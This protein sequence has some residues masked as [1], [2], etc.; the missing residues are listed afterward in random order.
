MARQGNRDRSRSGIRQP[1]DREQREPRDRR[2]QRDSRAPDALGGEQVEGRRAVVELLRAGNRRVKTVWLSSAAEPDETIAEIEELAGASLRVVGPE[3]LGGLVRTESHQGVMATASPLRPADLDELLSAPDAFLVALDG[4]TDPRN[5]GA[6]LRS[7]ETAGA[8]GA[9]IPRHRAA[10]ITP[11]V[12]KTA[13]GAIEY[14]PISL[15]GGIPTTLDRARRAQ[16]WTVGL[17]G[18]GDADLEIGRAHV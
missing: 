2:E 10:R 8:T 5:L 18:D 15:V 6:V 14:L 17:D 13:A 11:T 1:K 16:V 4:V 12:A 9:V 7:A 3:R